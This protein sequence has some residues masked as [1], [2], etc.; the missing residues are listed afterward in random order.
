MYACMYTFLPA[1][2][3][4]CVLRIQPGYGFNVYKVNARELRRYLMGPAPRETV[5]NDMAFLRVAIR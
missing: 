4:V 3:C 1:C 5:H 2:V